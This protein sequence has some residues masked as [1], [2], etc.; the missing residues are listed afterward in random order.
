MASSKAKFILVGIGLYLLSTGISYAAF[1][2]LGS[3]P[4]AP[5]T[6]EKL[7]SRRYK[8][9]LSAPKTET[10]PLTGAKFTKGEKDIWDARRPLGVMV[11]NHEEARPQSGLSRADVV[12]EAVAEG[13]ITRFLAVYYC[14]ASAEEI[15][16]G[17]IRS[18]RTY[19][20]DWISEYGDYPLYVHIGGANCNPTT[21]SGCLN[22]AKAD[23]IGQIE[24]YGWGVYN[25]LDGFSIGLPTIWRDTERLG[26]VAWEHTAYSTT[27]KLWEF[28]ANKRKLTATDEE[29]NRW[30]EKFVP[31]QFKDEAAATDR[32][33][34]GVSLS[35][36]EGYSA[37]DVKWDY[38]STSNSYKRLTGASPQKDL[39]NDEPLTAKTVIVAFM[40]ESRANDGYD[41]NLHLLYA[42]KGT[43]KTV[44]FLDGKNIEG[45]WSKKDRLSRTKFLDSSG[46][47]IKLN[48]GPIWIE[49]VPVG[50][51][52]TY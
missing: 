29:G 37:Y 48:P 42:D 38:D 52:V 8:V 44:V 3:R 35:F 31:W 14:G 27:D 47:E 39:N 18:A 25:D 22:G 43:G 12:Y 7:Q 9:A 11:E 1:T 21:G 40:R 20:L 45:T 33:T 5:L 10:C 36:W 32:G 17:P 23:A 13:G 46:K 4:G 51:K 24:T 6:G 49:I 26:P 2:S 28:A 15:Q 30:D 41:N 34:T 19:Y 50:S 16:V